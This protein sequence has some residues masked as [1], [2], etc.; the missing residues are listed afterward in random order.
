MAFTTLLLDA[1]E[2]HQL[3]FQDAGSLAADGIFELHDEVQF[4]LVLVLAG[5]TWMCASIIASNSPIS[6]KQVSHGTA[7]EVVWT[8]TPALLLLTIAYPSFALLY[9]LD[10]VVTPVL[11]VKVLGSQWFWSYELADLVSAE[12]DVVS[13]DSYLVAEPM[14]A[15][16]QLRLL[17]VDA[18]LVLPVWTHVRLLVTAN[19]VIHDFA[20]P[21][22]GLKLDA[23]PG[24]LNQTSVLIERE[25][26]YY[27][28]CS[29]LCGVWHGFMPIQVV[30]VSMEAFLGWVTASL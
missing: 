29:E 8:V 1:A 10:E 11:T 21:A 4:W 9:L 14:L 13:F 27:G 20:V 2:A 3:G 15:P 23:C 5:V 30:A 22:L 25:G 6:A 16:G 7:L 26:V 17:A 19:D 28:Q 24:R 12:G 18:P